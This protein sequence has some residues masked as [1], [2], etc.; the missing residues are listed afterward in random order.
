MTVVDPNGE[1]VVLDSGGYGGVIVTKS[2]SLTAPTGVYAGISVFPG[3]DGVVIA[4]AGINVILRGL[5]INSQGG[6]NGI[7]MTNGA[8]ISVENCVI[9]NF[10]VSSA[11]TVDAA[12]KVRIVDT[13]LRD[14][15]FGIK[16]RGG[17]A[18]DIVRTTVLGSGANGIEAYAHF[19]GATTSA[20]ISDTVVAGGNV[21]IFAFSD[22]FGAIARVS[23]TRSTTTGASYG[24]AAQ[25]NASGTSLLTVSDSMVS[26]NTT[27][28]A[29]IG[30]ATL[31]SLGNNAV[32]QNG[33]N[34]SGSITAVSPQ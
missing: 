34:T 2:I 29:V 32:R 20:A 5:T 31:E 1:V 27:G 19:S 22:T 7:N 8:S 11:I 30:G 4:T 24:M 3:A 23:V 6:N 15:F 33:A 26:G 16:L 28:L 21:G 14:N 18:A 17:A 13:L 25:S 12:S 10:S 9:A